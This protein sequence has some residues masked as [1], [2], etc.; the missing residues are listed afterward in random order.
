MLRSQ[1][2]SKASRKRSA[3]Q[4]SICE[5]ETTPVRRPVGSSASPSMKASAASSPSRPAASFQAKSS[6]WSTSSFQVPEPKEGARKPRR[7]LCAKRSVQRGNSPPMSIRVVT[8]ESRSSQAAA[9]NP[10][11]RSWWLK[12]PKAWL[13]S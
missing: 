9:S 2:A 1:A 12:P 11:S 4:F 13:R 10:A 8:P 5:G 7:P 3:V 6:R